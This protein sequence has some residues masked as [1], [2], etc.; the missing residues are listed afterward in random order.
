[1]NHQP[2]SEKN[3]RGN[4]LRAFSFT[5]QIGLTMASC[6]LVGVLQGKL[7]DS[8]LGTSPWLLLTCSLLGVA[9]SIKSLFDMNMK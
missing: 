8:L 4:I 9:A 2:H 5:T 1:M 7:L 3:Q 6:V